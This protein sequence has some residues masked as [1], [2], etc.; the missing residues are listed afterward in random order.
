MVSLI[1]NHLLNLR[2]GIRDRVS[3]CIP[4]CPGTHSVVQAGLKLRGIHLPLPPEYWD[5]RFLPLTTG[6]I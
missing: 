3:L 5:Q 4:G 6:L 2:G 1:F